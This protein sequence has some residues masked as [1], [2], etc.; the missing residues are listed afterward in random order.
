MVEYSANENVPGKLF[1][2]CERLRATLSTESCAALWRRADEINDGSHSACRLCLVGSGHAGYT[3]ASQSPLKGALMCARCHRTAG[4][5]IGKMICVSCY[6]RKREFFA[7]KNAKGT[8]PIR[9]AALHKRRIRYLHGPDVVTLVLNDSAD[10]DELI[11]AALRDSKS[12]IVFAFNSTPPVDI[13]Q[14]RLF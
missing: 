5:L 11:I 7:G 8:A 10:T 9:L 4:R 3:G 2:R 13:R 1:F 6:N 12:E 14:K